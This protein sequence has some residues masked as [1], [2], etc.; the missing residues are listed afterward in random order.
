M[1]LSNSSNFASSTW[2]PYATTLPWTLT[3][4][5][6]SKTVYVKY[7]GISGSEIGAAND[8]IDLTVPTVAKPIGQVLGASTSCGIYLNDYI[9]L[10]KQN[11]VT[12]VKKLQ[13]FLNSNLGINLPVTGYY[14]PLTYKA[15]EDFQVKYN[16]SV[17]SPW[18]PYGL[19]SDT[20]PTGYVYKT[21]QRW[22]NILM[23]ST[24]N[25]PVPAL[26]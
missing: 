1:E 10:G 3:S 9:K 19:T 5:A 24:L 13:V 25:L 7:R 4:G 26:P 14:G 6:G 16:N 23:C 11:D 20:T 18:V 21:T 2:Q 22:I 17:L 8:S 12:E 15:V